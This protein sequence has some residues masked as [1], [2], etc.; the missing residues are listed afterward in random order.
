MGRCAELKIIYRLNSTKQ[1]FLIR[2]HPVSGDTDSGLF[3]K[4]N[5]ESPAKAPKNQRVAPVGFLSL[6]PNYNRLAIPLGNVS[7]AIFVKVY[8]SIR[9]V[10]NVDTENEVC[11]RLIKFS[12]QL[13]K[14]ENYTFLNFIDN[15]SR[16]RNGINLVRLANLGALHR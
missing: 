6:P 3:A 16:Y 9:E 10:L 12:L 7:E 8:L 13:L 5:Q 4:D 14:F 15:R 2:S 11:F 1:T